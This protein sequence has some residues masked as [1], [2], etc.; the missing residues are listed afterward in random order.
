VGTSFNVR[1]NTMAIGQEKEAHWRGR[2][3]VG[4]I[5]AKRRSMEFLSVTSV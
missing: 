4:G 3:A 5:R 2:V 1:V